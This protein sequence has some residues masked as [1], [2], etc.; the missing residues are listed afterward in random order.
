MKKLFFTAVAVMALLS[1]CEKPNKCKCE[2]TLKP[3][4]LDLEVK[5]D[6]QIIERPEDKNCSQIKL[7]DVDLFSGAVTVDVSKLGSIKCVNY[8]E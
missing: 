6:D 4:F 5:L 3:S 8:H 2:F 1:S 7:E